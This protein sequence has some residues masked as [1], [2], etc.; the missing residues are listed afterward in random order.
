MEDILEELVGEI[1]DEYDNENAILKKEADGTYIALGS[2]SITDLNEHL[3]ESISIDADFET[4]AGF[5]ISGL[6][7]I[8]VAGDSLRTEDYEFTVLKM[9]RSSI[10][11]VRIM[12]LPTTF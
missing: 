5:M 7:R 6:G 3:P 12:A 4:L 1:Q 2:A 10:I 8:P 9:N 11:S